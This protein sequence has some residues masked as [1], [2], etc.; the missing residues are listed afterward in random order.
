MIEN[1]ALIEKFKEERSATVDIVLCILTKS[2][3]KKEK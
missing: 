1:S 3:I 2:I